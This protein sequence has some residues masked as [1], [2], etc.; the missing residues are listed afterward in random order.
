MNPMIA[1]ADQVGAP[2][3]EE[4]LVSWINAPAKQSIIPTRGLIFPCG[5]HL[6]FVRGGSFALLRTALSL[7]EPFSR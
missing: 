2:P 3:R 5:M 1:K 4:A 7:L 6:A